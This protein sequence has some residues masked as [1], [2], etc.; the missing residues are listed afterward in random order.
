ME[1]EA[2]ARHRAHLRDSGSN[3]G[4]GLGFRQLALRRASS[5]CGRAL[6]RGG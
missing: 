1:A 6:A 5:L 4:G 3:D 2:E